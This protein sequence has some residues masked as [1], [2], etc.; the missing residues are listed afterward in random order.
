MWKA[1][2]PNF[3][4]ISCLSNEAI[5][6]LKCCCC[7]KEVNIGVCSPRSDLPQF[8]R[9]SPENPDCKVSFFKASGH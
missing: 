2:S 5:Q 1:L 6:P 7:V 9:P 4:K 8:L 3:L